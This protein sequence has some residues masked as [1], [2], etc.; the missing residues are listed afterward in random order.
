[1]ALARILL[2]EDDSRLA[3]LTARYLEGVGFVVDRE[4]DG[5]RA[6]VRIPKEQPDAVVLDLGLPGI[7]GLEVCRRVRQG[8]SG[9]ILVLTARDDEVDQVLGLEL[10]A[11]AYVVKPTPPRVLAARLKALI[12]RS[13]GEWEEGERVV[14]GP[15]ILD[16]N[17]Y[18]ARLHGD[19]LSLSSGEFELLWVLVR[20]RGRVL[21]RDQIL[22]ALHGEDSEQTSR[23]IDM[24]VSRLRAQLGD[25]PR[26]PRWIRTIRSQGYLFSSPE[27]S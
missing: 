21:D 23:S 17:R 22:A 2:I 9:P 25:N 20:F 14:V 5:L 24:M 1:M 19:D 6:S 16:R 10:G 4:D 12:R 3:E 8:Y 26:A 7:D 11:D 15:L 18:Q 13:R 27:A